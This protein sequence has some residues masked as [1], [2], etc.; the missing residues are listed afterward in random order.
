M[1]LA[2]PPTASGRGPSSPQF[3]W[4]P[5]IY[6]YTLCRRTTKFD[7]VTRGEGRG[8]AHLP[9]QERERELQRSQIFTLLSYVCLHPVTQKDQIWHGNTYGDGRVL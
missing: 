4:F 2:A 5:S 6:A 7:V 9:S 8:Q 3:W 1:G